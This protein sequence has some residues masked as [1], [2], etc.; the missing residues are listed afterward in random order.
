M[1]DLPPVPGSF[2]EPP[3]S[4]LPPPPY[5][6]PGFAAPPPPPATPGLAP[7]A[8]PYGGPQGA[9]YAGPQQGYPGQWAPPPPARGFTP[10]VAAGGAGALLYQFSGV[11][12]WSIG[13][14]VV[15]IV[16]PFASGFYFPVMPVI[17]GLNAIRAIQ[18]GRLIGG[19]VG[20]GL[21]L[22]GGLVSLLA[23]MSTR[24]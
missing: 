1:A 19:L 11:A 24:S 6:G 17:G 16:A 12:A 18:R 22:L 2:P 9:P 21:N 10:A 5:T 14:G 7:P 23:Y 20:L 15:A 3:P 8:G 4:N 13:F